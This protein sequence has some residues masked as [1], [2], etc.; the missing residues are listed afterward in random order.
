MVVVFFATSKLWEELMLGEV[1][2][3]RL[4]SVWFFL[5]GLEDIVWDRYDAVSGEYG[6]CLPPQGYD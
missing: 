4:Y 3:S 5:G 2:V 6:C 1:P